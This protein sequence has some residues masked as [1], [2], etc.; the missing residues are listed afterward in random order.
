MWRCLHSV[1]TAVRP[2]ASQRGQTLIEYGLI[3]TLIG[4]VGII[5]LG[6]FGIDMAETLD[7]VEN[8][9]G[10]GDPDTVPTGMGDEDVTAPV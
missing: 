8:A 9:L 5:F 2:L 6:S 4:I 7:A 3:L 10:L 1:A